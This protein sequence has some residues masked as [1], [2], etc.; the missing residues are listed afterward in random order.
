M[1][2]HAQKPNTG[3]GFTEKP[4]HVMPKEAKR[5]RRHTKIDVC[6]IGKRVAGD[7]FFVLPKSDEPTDDHLIRYAGLSEIAIIAAKDVILFPNAD[8]TMQNMPAV[9]PRVKR[10]VIFTQSALRLF[11]A[12]RIALAAEHRKHA[13]SGG[14]ADVCT[15]IFDDLALFLKITQ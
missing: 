6:A 9:S 5:I 15:E 11:D 2:K 3:K 12:N 8:D 7:V 4:K 1:P 10:N 14:G 13:F